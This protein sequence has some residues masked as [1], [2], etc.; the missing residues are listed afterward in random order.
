M[1]HAHPRPPTLL[2]SVQRLAALG[3]RDGSLFSSSRRPCESPFHR[4]RILRPGKAR[5]IFR[6][7]FALLDVSAFHKL[8]KMNVDHAARSARSSCDVQ[9]VVPS[10]VVLEPIQNHI[11]LTTRSRVGAL[12]PHLE[13]H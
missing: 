5:V 1:Q 10:I 8:A 11:G 4:D 3:S 12:W 2:A 9:S 6:R 7:T 13:S